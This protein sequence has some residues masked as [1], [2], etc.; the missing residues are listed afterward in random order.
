MTPSFIVVRTKNIL[1]KCMRQKS[2][3]IINHSEQI[4]PPIF[5][6]EKLNTNFKDTYNS[7]VDYHLVWGNLY[8]D[9]LVKHTS[10]NTERIKIVGNYKLD[11]IKRSSN[12][13]IEKKKEKKI[14]KILVVSNFLL[15]DYNSYNWKKF[16]KAHQVKSAVPINK[17]MGCIRKRFLSEIK[18]IVTFYPDKHFYIRPHPGENTDIYHEYLRNID[19]ISIT[20]DSEFKEDVINADFVIM[21]SSSSVF[22]LIVSG[23]QFCSL[24]VGRLPDDFAQPPIDI[25]NWKKTA[26]IIDILSSNRDFKFKPEVNQDAFK[27]AMSTTNLHSLD[28]NVETLNEILS[29]PE[30]LIKYSIFARYLHYTYLLEALIK[31]LILRFGYRL[32]KLGLNNF[33]YSFAKDHLKHR[34]KSLNY[35]PRRYTTKS[36]KFKKQLCE[37]QNHK[38]S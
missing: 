38:I 2:K 22:E 21:H 8:K 33:I 5:N 12:K 4:F 23:K 15:G 31:D 6:K 7:I 24:D 37:I 36:K 30:Q 3:L 34:I 10:T 14:S 27:Y 26:D 28:E 32:K 19:N 25:F 13:K 16:K 35:I 17:I 18:K 9:K 1:S 11:L 20:N 29:K